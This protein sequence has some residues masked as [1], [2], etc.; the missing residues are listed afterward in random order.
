MINNETKPIIIPI[1]TNVRNIK[2]SQRKKLIIGFMGMLKFPQGVDMIIDCLPELIKQIPNVHIE[3]IGSG[4]EEHRL[5]MKARKHHKSIT[6]YGFKENQNEIEKII[7]RWSIGTAT[8]VPAES[9]ESYWGD[10][11][12]IKVYLSQ[13][14]PVITTNVSYFAFELKKARAG[15][16]VPYGDTQSFIIAIKDILKKKTMYQ[17]NALTLAQKYHYKKI[18]PELFK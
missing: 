11:S 12:K 13:A 3:I 1:G 16:I 5:K 4:P 9:N 14:V 15:I 6:F 10:P 8:Y 7:R 17:K 2:I 18:Y